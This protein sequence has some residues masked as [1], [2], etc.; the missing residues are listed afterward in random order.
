[1]SVK[2]ITMNDLHRDS[3]VLA[4]KLKQYNPDILVPCMIGGLIPGAIIAKEL[5]IKDVRPIS[6]DRI[7]DRRPISYNIQDP[8][9]IKNKIVVIV[10]DDL[11]SGIGPQEAKQYFIGLGAKEVIIASIYIRSITQGCDVYVVIN[12]D[13]K[14][15]WKIQKGGDKT[16]K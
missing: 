4:Q 13:V 9:D 10:E 1:M 7:G 2:K 16:R 8:D 5:D 6:I 12:E 3:V 11:R 14:Y 15:T